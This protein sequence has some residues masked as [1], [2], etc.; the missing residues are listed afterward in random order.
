M[1]EGNRPTA[2]VDANVLLNL[3]TPRVDGRD[4]A[5]SGDDP[6]KTFL[7]AYDVHAP[8]EVLGEVG[9]AATGTDLLASAADAVL[10]AADHIEAHDVSG[11]VGGSLD[12]G[13]DPGESFGIWLAN[14]LSAELF[15]TDE[16]G[17]ENL[18]IVV[19]HLDDA[20]TLFST[21]H[22]LCRLGERG[23]LDRQYTDA[24]LTYLCESKSW[25]SGYVGRLRERHLHH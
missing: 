4:V 8:R 19:L 9:A 17:T 3:A 11:A 10:R 2:V 21:P 14:E 20:N 15:V 13:L 12:Y 22:V 6:L 25:N 24:V 7:T 18:P 1:I 23:L 16:F 5:P